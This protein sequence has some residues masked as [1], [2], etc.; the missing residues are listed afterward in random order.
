MYFQSGT[1]ISKNFTQKEYTISQQKIRF[2]GIVST[3]KDS[4]S[5]ICISDPG[6]FIPGLISSFY[7]GSRQINF[8]EVISNLV[9]SICIAAK[10]KLEN[11]FLF[12]SA[13]GGMGALLSSTY[14][15]QKGAGLSGQFANHDL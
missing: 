1:K 2:E 13:S 3:F 15:S 7:V 6:H 10:I 4:A 11:T 9:E 8:A 5:A 12:G 14:F